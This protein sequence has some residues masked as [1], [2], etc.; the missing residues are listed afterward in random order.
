M[1]DVKDVT[2]LKKDDQGWAPKNTLDPNFESKHS[3]KK[4]DLFINC[5]ASDAM[6]NQSLEFRFRS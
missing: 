5:F 1:P 3:F 2:L 4:I 6:S